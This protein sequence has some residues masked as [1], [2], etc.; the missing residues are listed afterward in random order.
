MFAW[1]LRE[2]KKKINICLKKKKTP[3]IVG[4]TGLY[5]NTITKGISKIPEID[6]KTRS[7]VRTLYNRLGYQK[8]YEKLLEGNDMVQGCRFSIGGGKIENNAMPFLHKYFGNPF[9]SLIS[10]IFFS[11]PFNDVYCGFRGFNRNKFLN[12]NPW[13]SI[14]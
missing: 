13:L 8:F 10:K 3:I 7:K 2:A 4:G 9:F 1:G 14:N 12:L 11:L 6:I 5:F